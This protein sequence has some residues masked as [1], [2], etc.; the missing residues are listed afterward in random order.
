MSL[1]RFLERIPIRWRLAVT[2]A[3]LT[4]VILALFAVVIGAFTADRMRAD[5]DN[6]LR[7]T[8]AD[9]TARIGVTR[10]PTPGS[11]NLQ[12]D[13][14]AQV[15]V[16]VAG[17]GDATVRVVRADGT[18]VIGA[19]GS[20]ALGPPV[21][22]VR[23]VG[24]YH[25]I[26]EPLYVGSLVPVAYLQYGKERR[27]LT[28]TIDLLRGFLG[29]GVVAGT[30]LA[31]LAGLAVARRAM[32]PVG[33]LTRAAREIARTRDPAVR[34]PQPTGDD[35][36]AELARTL[37]EMLRALDAARTETEAALGRQREFV[38]DASHE[39]RTPL[40]SVLANLELLESGLE[41]EDREAASSA[42]RSSRRM[43]RLVGDLLLLA[44]ADT[45]AG[46]AQ[47]E[48]D[49][50]AVV[51]EAAGE[52]AAVAPDHEISV[53]A[54]APVAVR[55]N[56]DELHRLVLN[57]LENAVFHTP[58]G[59][60][61]RATARRENAAAVLEVAD[62]GPGVPADLRDR[63]FERFVRAEGDAR[64]GGGTGTGLGLAIVR[65]VSD[66]HGGEVDVGDE[67]GGGARFSVRL[68]ASAPAEAGE[69]S[70]PAAVRGAR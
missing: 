22:G 12:S 43:R 42:L 5:F 44:R 45:G 35:E 15:L 36:V 24:P 60:A 8:A 40:T 49:L 29:L 69:S 21:R 33:R 4:F 7:A 37:D 65:A 30:V 39:L 31:L 59:T 63:V 19:P 6:D 13:D 50:A 55:G 48:V 28:K 41:G 62:T 27:A 57:L 56:A 18:V 23:D 46:Q 3:L 68:P 26:S 2:S 58:R 14:V 53:E 47:A 17:S 34:L 51:R 64:G 1:P 32:S 9:L 54:P 25:V 67:P 10:G 70:P 16:D 61:V 20:G 66:R 11:V 38:A 52:V